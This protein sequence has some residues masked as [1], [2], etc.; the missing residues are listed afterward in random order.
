VGIL[1]ASA[2]WSVIIWLAYRFPIWIV[3]IGALLDSW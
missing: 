2:I 3:L 1:L